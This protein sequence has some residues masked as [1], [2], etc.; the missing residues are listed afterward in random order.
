MVGVAAVFDYYF[1]HGKFLSA[2]VGTGLGLAQ[3]NTISSDIDN[4]IG[5]CPS[6][7]PVISPRIGVE[8]WNHVR[9][10]I[11]ARITQRDYNIAAFRIGYSFG[12]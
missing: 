5:I 7:G 11:E 4:S 10:S 12:K 2:F 3:R 6:Y 8:L 9:F 1:H